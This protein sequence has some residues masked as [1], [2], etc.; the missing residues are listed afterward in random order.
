MSGT[1]TVQS[2]SKESIRVPITTSA[3]PTATA[4]QFSVSTS[5]VDPGSWVNGTWSGSW[6]PSTQETT[7]LTPTLGSTAAGATISLTAGTVYWL[8]AR[9][10][11]GA[12]IGVWPVGRI[13][14][15]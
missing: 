14:C 2:E 15:P 4:P 5:Q 6:D 7:A 3:D 9:I 8:W 13:V 12:E 1:Q 11:V 10:T